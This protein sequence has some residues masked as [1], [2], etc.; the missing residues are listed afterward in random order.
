MGVHAA[1]EQQLAEDCQVVRRRKQPRVRSHAAH[2]PGIFV[3]DF[4]ADKPVAEV[5]I[6]FC[7]SDVVP[8]RRGWV[9]ERVVQAQRA[10]EVF[11]DKNVQAPAAHPLN[12]FSQQD[13]S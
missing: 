7:R 11:L 6:F 12:D 4:A 8:Q 2:H 13:D 5:V 10:E 9:E 3:V 1:V